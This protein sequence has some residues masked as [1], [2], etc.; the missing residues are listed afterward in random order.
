MI[1]SGSCATQPAV[2]AQT[3]G[4]HSRRPSL[5]LLN[6]SSLACHRITTRLLP[7]YQVVIHPTL[8]NLWNRVNTCI[9]IQVSPHP[10]LPP[11]ATFTPPPGCRTRTEHTPPPC[12]CSLPTEPTL[13]PFVV[14][15][16]R[17]ETVE[18]SE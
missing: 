9:N 17:E 4:A 15:C 5:A 18:V 14:R 7:L 2:Q 10:V 6:R 16:H 1:C 3:A 8:I 13:P 11:P 12:T